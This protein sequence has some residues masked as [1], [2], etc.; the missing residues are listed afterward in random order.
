MDGMADVM[1]VRQCLSRLYP[2]LLTPN[3]LAVPM[4]SV[5]QDET[6]AVSAHQEEC[7]AL[8]HFGEAVRT[9]C[10]ACAIDAEC[11]EPAQRAI[12]K[13]FSSCPIEKIYHQ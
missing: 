11:N 7:R 1:F 6:M 4:V 8:E 10:A 9:K 3:T 2:Q 5:T 13:M 12:L